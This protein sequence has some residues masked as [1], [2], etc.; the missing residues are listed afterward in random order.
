MLPYLCQRPTETARRK[1]IL[2]LPGDQTVPAETRYD[3]RRSRMQ[4][5]RSQG[6]IAVWCVLRGG[7]KGPV[8][9]K[10]TCFVLFRRCPNHGLS[11]IKG[12]ISA[13]RSKWFVACAVQSGGSNARHFRSDAADPEQGNLDDQRCDTPSRSQNR[14]FARHYQLRMTFQWFE[15]DELFICIQL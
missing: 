7:K 12:C 8:G 4:Q 10:G 15:C 6:S 5:N 3:R 1:P 11:T 2:S 9:S 14:P 13:P